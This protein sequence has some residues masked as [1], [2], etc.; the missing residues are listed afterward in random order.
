VTD[1]VRDTPVTVTLTLREW[2]LVRNQLRNAADDWR[3]FNTDPVI[4]VRVDHVANI[5]DEQA[6]HPHE[7]ERTGGGVLD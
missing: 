3:R 6:I 1:D 4:A 2:W 5:I 7:A